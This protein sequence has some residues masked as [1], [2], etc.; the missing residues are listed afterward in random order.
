MQQ[1]LLQNSQKSAF[2]VNVYR[3]WAY[4]HQI[5]EFEVEMVEI[6]LDKMVVNEDFVHNA[7]DHVVM[8]D[9]LQNGYVTE[10]KRLV[11][12]CLLLEAKCWLL[13]NC[14]LET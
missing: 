11:F 8:L 12:L 6:L 9:T 14:I 13:E 2:L 5:S 10:C 1:L 7:W 3:V 4:E